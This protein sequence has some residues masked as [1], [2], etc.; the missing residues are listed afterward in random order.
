MSGR[1]VILIMDNFSAHKAAFE[2]LNSDPSTMLKN[3]KVISSSK[4]NISASAP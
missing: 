3:I 1:E 4:Y 2:Y